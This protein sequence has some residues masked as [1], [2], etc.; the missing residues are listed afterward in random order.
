M[1]LFCRGYKTAAFRQNAKQTK[2][3]YDYYK[4]NSREQWG[5]HRTME[6]NSISIFFDIKYFRLMKGTKAQCLDKKTSQ[7]QQKIM[8]IMNKTIESNWEIKKQ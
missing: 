6:T 1:F 5:K 8:S 7:K 3:N 4:Q 2:I